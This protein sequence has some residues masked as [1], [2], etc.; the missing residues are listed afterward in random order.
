MTGHIPAPTSVKYKEIKNNRIEVVIEPCYPGYGITIGNALR[1]VL[2]SSLPG[3]AV[4]AVKIQGIQHEYDT[5]EHVKEDIVEIVMNLK[6]LR[7]RSHSD[8]PVT[9]ELHAKGEK[10]V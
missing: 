10:A 4:C 3:A 6:K 7:V 1:R 5:L 8:E 9:L 2:L